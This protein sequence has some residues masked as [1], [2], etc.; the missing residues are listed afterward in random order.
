M[1]TESTNLMSAELY[2]TNSLIS[3][4]LKLTALTTL[5]LYVAANR[6]QADKLRLHRT[7]HQY[8]ERRLNN[9]SAKSFRED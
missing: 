1:L 2:V 9:L 7:I 3:C 6:F 5:R 8:D 4:H